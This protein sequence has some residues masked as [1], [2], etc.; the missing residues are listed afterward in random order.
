MNSLLTL[1][2]LLAVLPAIYSQ[3]IA[4]K[5]EDNKLRIDCTYDALT[6]S[7]VNYEFSFSKMGRE[8]III[9]NM[10]SQYDPKNKFSASVKHMPPN[11]Y[12]MEM[13]NFQLN[14][15]TTFACKAKNTNNLN[16]LVE[17]GKLPTCSAY[18]LLL[19]SSPWLLLALLSLQLLQWGGPAFI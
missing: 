5:T 3:I 14:E 1:A 12:R 8:T 15:S 6:M 4:C 13:A 7:P 16:I 19:H 10:T 9:T 17:K 2:A 11:S 18:S